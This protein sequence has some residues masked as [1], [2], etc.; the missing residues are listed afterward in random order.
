MKKKTLYYYLNVSYQGWDSKK[1][2]TICKAV[3]WRFESGSGFGFG[4]RDLGFVFKTEKGARNA[5]ARVKKLRKRVKCEI[6]K[7]YY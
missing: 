1:D 3:G 7:E 6:S 4:R 5:V 2:D